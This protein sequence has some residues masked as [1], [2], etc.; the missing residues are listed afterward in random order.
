ML[1]RL[2][3][4][5]VTILLFVLFLLK[6]PFPLIAENAPIGPSE[7]RQLFYHYLPQDYQSHLDKIL[8]FPLPKMLDAPSSASSKEEFMQEL[9]DNYQAITAIDLYQKG[10]E[11][12]QRMLATGEDDSL[13]RDAHQALRNHPITIIII[14]G[15]FGEFIEQTPFDEA[16]QKN[17]Q[18]RSHFFQQWQTHYQE[19]LLQGKSLTDEQYSLEHTHLKKPGIGKRQRP[20][21]DLVHISGLRV[22]GQSSSERDAIQLITLTVPILSTE[23]LGDQYQMS[24]IYLR[25]LQKVFNILGT[26]PEN[27]VFI[28]YSRGGPIALDMVAKMKAQEIPWLSHTKGV[29]TLGGVTLGT[30][31][32][33]LATGDRL[34]NEEE[35]DESFHQ[36]N[37]IRQLARDLEYTGQDPDAPRWQ[38]IL[39]AATSP[40]TINRNTQRFIHLIKSF[41]PQESITLPDHTSNPLKLSSM[42][43]ALRKIAKKTTPYLLLNP[44]MPLNLLVHFALKSFHIEKFYS[45]YDTNI[46]KFKALAAQ[47]L[48]GVKQLSTKSRIRWWSRHQLPHEGIRYYAMT[49]VMPNPQASATEE[50]LAGNAYCFNTKSIDYGF[51]YSSYKKLAKNSGFYLN[52]SQMA[53]HKTQ[54]WNEYLAFINPYYGDNPLKKSLLGIAGTHHWG[55]SLPIVGKMST[56]KN[57]PFPRLSLLQTMAATVALDLEHHQI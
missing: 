19:L 49:T 24:N 53:L 37:M 27:L 41:L 30:E 20:L 57:N 7:F 11:E 38:R 55:F 8:Y 46:K 40:L 32:S 15:I 14:P 29:I 18:K 3:S 17:Y 42:L 1:T 52:D 39:V 13:L 6:I 9:G 33:D 28:G 45:D 4:S 10:K 47:T 31:L 50:W 44:S 56:G 21:K 35:L 36:M 43:K 2:S 54:L 48:M 34:N 22:P 26:T 5:Q 25:R 12:T 51:L 16:F 23:S